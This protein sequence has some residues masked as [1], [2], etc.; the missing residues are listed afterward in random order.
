MVLKAIAS[1]L[2]DYI[3]YLTVYQNTYFLTMSNDDS[4]VGLD[5]YFF[6]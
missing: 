6:L 5:S 1:V 2:Q 4:L 3:P